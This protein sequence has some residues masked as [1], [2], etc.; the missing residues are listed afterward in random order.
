MAVEKA[1]SA[2]GSKSG[3]VSGSE[4]ASCEAA[5]KREGRGARGARLLRCQHAW[6][7]QSYIAWTCYQEP[8][9]ACDRIK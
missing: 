3:T 1:S 2:S 6:Q 5:C 9:F 8:S 7:R 4:G